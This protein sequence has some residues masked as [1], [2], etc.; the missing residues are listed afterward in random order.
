MDAPSPEIVRIHGVAHGGQGVGRG[1]GEDADPRVWLVDGALPGERVTAYRVREAKN[2]IRGE[3]DEILE[4]AP[5]RVTPP[6]SY[7]ASCG[8]CNWQ[9]VDPAAQIELKREVVNGQLRHLNV[10]VSRAVASPKAL[11]YRRRARLHYRREGD[12]FELGFRRQRSH[13]IVDL[14]HCV[15]LDGPLN[16]AMER[17]RGIADILPWEGEVVGL[18]DGKRAILGLPG[19]APSEAIDVAIRERAL[20]DTLVGIALR[21]RRQRHSVGV[22]SMAIDGGEGMISMAA[23]PFVFTQAQAEQNALLIRHVIEASRPRSK[24]VLELFAGAGNFTRELGR[25]ASGVWALDDSRESISY[26]RA[27]AEEWKLPINAKHGKAENLLP[28]IARNN[29][30]YEVTVLDPPRRGLGRRGSAAV[31]QITSERIVYVACDPSTLARDLRV[32]VEG[33]FRVADVTIFDF[34]P[35]TAEIEVVATLEAV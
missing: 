2:M 19:V 10:E 13:A 6:C 25:H 31:A 12:D 4:S 1:E 7:A 15:V 16:R 22:T 29:G 11:G 30:T 24:K 21:G 14:D 26:L 32:M 17:L 18:S 20:D 28:K 23:G 33:G 8:G 3:T 34:M 9:Y 27:L 35:M 5:T